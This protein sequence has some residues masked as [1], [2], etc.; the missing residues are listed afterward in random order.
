MVSRETAERFASTDGE[1]QTLFRENDVVVD[2]VDNLVGKREEGMGL[3]REEDVGSWMRCLSSLLASVLLV[4]A[5]R[6]REVWVGLHA[7]GRAGEPT[8]LMCLYGIL[9][10]GCPVETPGRYRSGEEEDEEE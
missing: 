3:S 5:D 1:V 10:D 4:V 9:L 7:G 6:Q 2:E 8:L